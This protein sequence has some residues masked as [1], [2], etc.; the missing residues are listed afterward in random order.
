MKALVL[1]N[2]FP[3]AQ[4][5][6]RGVFNLRRFQALNSRGSIRVVVPVQWW[7]RMRHP[8]AWFDAPDTLYQGVVA[9]YPTCWTLP[10]IATRWHAA[11]I[12]RTIRSHVLKIRR[13]FQFDV[14]LGA[15]AYPD[16][17]VARRLAEDARCPFVALVM[18]SDI[19]ELAKRPHLR[20]QISDALIHA[21]RVVA[22]SADLKRKVVDLGVPESNVIL[23]R[24]GVDGEKFFIRDRA[25]ARGQL[26]DGWAG[27]LICFVG[28]LTREKGP[29]LLIEAVARMPQSV[30]STLRVVFIG[31]GVM[32]QALASRARQL[33][34]EGVVRFEGRRPPDEIPLWIGAADLLCLP[35]RREGC[36]NVVLEALASG[37]P[38]VAARV[39]GVPEL[40]SERNGIIA[41]P[42]DPDALADALM[43][44]LERTWHPA[45]LRASVPSLTWDV[46]G[47]KLEEILSQAV[48][49]AGRGEATPRKCFTG[50]DMP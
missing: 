26:N 47:Q 23:Q 1:T 40:L 8:A 11:A 17:V 39:G 38:V 24:N 28:N 10:R 48:Y 13:D 45:D 46:L 20:G 41:A 43:R 50:A 14:V 49:R 33:G 22:L 15:F 30:P 21:D 44:G 3:S 27:R 34:L 37:R 5:P 19:N 35:S 42:E 25:Q 7:R 9:T 6:N 18:G 12:Y 29:D 16:V 31:D 4:E 2:L 32:R 36:P